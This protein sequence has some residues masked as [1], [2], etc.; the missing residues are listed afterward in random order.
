MLTFLVR[1]TMLATLSLFAISV[2][3]FA[4]VQMPP[5]DYADAYLVQT[6]DM[7]NSCSGTWVTHFTRHRT[8]RDQ[9][10][11]RVVAKRR[12]ARLRQRWWV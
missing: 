8:L 4:I 7:G 12:H 3:T 1:R 2:I 5:G 11:G 9:C 10:C 6:G